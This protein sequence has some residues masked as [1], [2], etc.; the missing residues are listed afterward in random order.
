MRAGPRASHKSD[1][2]IF[3]RLRSLGRKVPAKAVDLADPVIALYAANLSGDWSTIYCYSLA[4]AEALLGEQIIPV[5]GDSDLSAPWLP[6]M[7]I[8][9]RRSGKTA[10][11]YS[12]LRRVLT[13]SAD[14]LNQKEPNLAREICRYVSVFD[15]ISFFPPRETIEITA[16]QSEQR[17]W[18]IHRWND[19][20]LSLALLKDRHPTLSLISTD[21]FPT[22]LLPVG[23]DTGAVFLRL[24]IPGG[25]FPYYQAWTRQRKL[26]GTANRETRFSLNFFGRTLARTAAHRRLIQRYMALSSPQIESEKME[27]WGRDMARALPDLNLAIEE[28]ELEK[29][30]AA[31]FTL[32][33][34]KRH[35]STLPKGLRN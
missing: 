11:A 18:T 23:S 32:E 6:W 19:G 22:D 31:C 25:A 16:A 20:A 33:D 9:L 24:M 17:N 21:N 26:S 30:V 27:S 35:W 15:R 5:T 3:P 2:V 10:R 12:V 4:L 8:P 28:V 29:I 1:S 13:A 14:W 34:V 7:V